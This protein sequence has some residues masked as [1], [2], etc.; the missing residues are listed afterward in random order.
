LKEKSF[1]WQVKPEE[2]AGGMPRHAR[3]ER[4]EVPKEKLKLHGYP[5]EPFSYGPTKTVAQGAC[6]AHKGK[7]QELIKTSKMDET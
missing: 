5:G 4:G 3:L 6:E 7:W 1:K 2:H